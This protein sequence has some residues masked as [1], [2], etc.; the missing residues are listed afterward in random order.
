GT[1]AEREGAERSAGR[2]AGEL[3]QGNGRFDL[4]I[5]WSAR[6]AARGRGGDGE[7]VGRSVEDEETAAELDGDGGL[8]GAAAERDRDTGAREEAIGAAIAAG[9]GED[10]ERSVGREEPTEEHLVR[11]LAARRG[12]Q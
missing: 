4:A 2:D 7:P 8:L 1:C 10:A 9:D 11:P 3:A 6:S 12:L 5:A